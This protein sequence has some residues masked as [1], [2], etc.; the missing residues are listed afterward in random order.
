MVTN[1]N[2]NEGWARELNR[3]IA[4]ASHSQIF[5]R[6]EVLLNSGASDAPGSL[7]PVR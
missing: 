1:A 2:F 4:E 5:A 6:E 3:M 7:R